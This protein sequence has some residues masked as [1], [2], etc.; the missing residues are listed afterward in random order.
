MAQTRAARRLLTALLAV[1]VA[2]LV[3]DVAGSPVGAAVRT[4]AAAVVGPVQRALSAAPPDELARLER[5]N[6]RLE[7]MLAAGRDELARLEATDAL[8]GSGSVEGRTVVTARVVGTGL[9]AIGGRSVTLDAGARDGVTVDSTVVAA[10]GL[11]GRVVSVGP[12]TCDVQVLG[13]TGAVVGVRVGTV[14]RLATVGPPT[15]SEPVA[16]PRGS[17]TLTFVEPGNPAVG[18]LVRTLGSVGE[19][20]YAAGLMVGMVSSVDPDRDAAAGQ[21]TRTATVRPAVDVDSLDVVAVLVPQARTAPRRP[22]VSR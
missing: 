16:R 4:G 7:A 17:L 19:R 3:A 5:E 9:S 11:V 12:W 10:P 8:A 20:P 6:V 21:V 15:A 2:L 22:V 13:S 14:G 1:T 18:D